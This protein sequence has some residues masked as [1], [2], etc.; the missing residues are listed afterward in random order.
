MAPGKAFRDMYLDSNGNP[1][2][3]LSQNSP[4]ASGVPGSVA[5]IFECMKYA[6]LPFKKLIQPAIDLAEKGFTLA[7]G[8]A[9][10]LN[11]IKDH[12]I[13]MNKTV[14]A[15]A[16]LSTSVINC[17]DCKVP[18]FISS[19]FFIALIFSI[20]SKIIPPLLGK[21]MVTTVVPL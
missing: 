16:R 11:H 1:Q 18:Y 8:E 5:G 2:M 12:L 10:G 17:T 14:P 4:L 21:G 3:N 13:K 7:P 9:S 19:M 15:K 6:K 20:C